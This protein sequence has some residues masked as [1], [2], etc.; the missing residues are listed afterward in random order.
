MRQRI[1]LTSSVFVL[2]A[3][4]GCSGDPYNI[5][6]QYVEG[7]VTVDN[8]PMKGVNI[9]FVPKGEGE[10]ATGTTDENGRY[11][12]TSANGP[13]LKGA[14]AG[15][16][17]VTMRKIE[18]TKSGET[19]LD[20]NGMPL[21]PQKRQAPGRVLVVVKQLLPVIYKDLKTT[22]FSAKVEKKRKNVFNFEIDSKAK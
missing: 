22:P 13:S 16:Y 14:L 19:Q 15:E 1:Y 20:E 7:V 3:L 17:A 6:V 21:P 18:S 4:C 11:R 8:A 9:T 5:P 10:L 2:A 12:L